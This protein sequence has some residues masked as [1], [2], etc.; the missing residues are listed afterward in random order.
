MFVCIRTSGGVPCLLSMKMYPC[1]ALIASVYASMRNFEFSGNISR[2]RYLI[3]VRSQGLSKMIVYCALRFIVRAN[4][5]LA[6]RFWVS[7][8]ILRL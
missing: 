8:N 5:P 7:K 2:A 4:F 6:K 3:C 1:G